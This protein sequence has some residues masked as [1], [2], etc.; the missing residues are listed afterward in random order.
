MKEIEKKLLAAVEEY[1]AGEESYGDNTQICVDPVNGE[2]ELIP[3]SELP[4]DFDSTELD[5]YDV[6]DLVMMGSE[7]SG[8]WIPDKEAIASV[9]EEY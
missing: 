7:G 8:R 4:E 2:V 6:M 9:A 5:Y 3:E 1:I